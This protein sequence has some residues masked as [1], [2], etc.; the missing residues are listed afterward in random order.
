MWKRC[1]QGEKDAE[2]AQPASKAGHAHQ[3]WLPHPHQQT[4]ASAFQRRNQGV[5]AAAT[6]FRSREIQFHSIW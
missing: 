6:K 5:E 2:V 3:T 4:T 1:F